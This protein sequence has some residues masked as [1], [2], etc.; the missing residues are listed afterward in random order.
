MAIRTY[1]EVYLWNRDVSQT[2]WTV[3][4]T[5]WCKGPHI[6]PKEYQ[7]EAVAFYPDGRGYVTNSEGNTR[8]ST[9]SPQCPSNPVR[10]RVAF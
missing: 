9:S 8:P 5:T 10:I 6:T 7:G 2:V 4:P 1:N 3:F